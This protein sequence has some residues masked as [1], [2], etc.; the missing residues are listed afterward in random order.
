MP[1]AS[2]TV[3]GKMAIN[4]SAI[5]TQDVSQ[6]SVPTV[7]EI[8]SSEP[9]VS[10]VFTPARPPGQLV[11]FYNGTTGGFQLYVVLNSGIRFARVV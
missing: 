6:Q 3:S 7:L 8:L 1:T 9:D 11:G 4:P 5:A 2:I 10:A